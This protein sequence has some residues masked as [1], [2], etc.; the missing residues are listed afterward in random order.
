[1]KRL[2]LKQP[3]NKTSENNNGHASKV[4]SDFFSFSLRR[5][6][7]VTD[8]GQP[9][10]PAKIVSFPFVTYRVFGRSSS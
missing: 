7:A 4:W 6:S 2:V 8:V 1:M 3:K 5:D 10:S 9:Q